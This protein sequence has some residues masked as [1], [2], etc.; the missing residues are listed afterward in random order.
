M[1]GGFT[2]AT[3]NKYQGLARAV[4]DL[5]EQIVDDVSDFGNAKAQIALAQKVQWLYAIVKPHMSEEGAE[6]ATELGNDIGRDI[7]KA[8]VLFELINSDSGVVTLIESGG[9]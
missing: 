8:R 2:M 4:I 6:K 7:D 1:P 3:T 9:W 5:L